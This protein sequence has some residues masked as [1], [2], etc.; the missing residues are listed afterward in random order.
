VSKRLPLVLSALALA[1][2]L[3]GATP[4]GQAA[5]DLVRAAVPLALYAN[6]AG[7]LQGHTASAAPVGGQVPVLDASGGLAA[8]ALRYAPGVVA[9]K[10]VAVNGKPVPLEVGF[11]TTMRAAC[12]AGAVVLGGGYD[13][14]LIAAGNVKITA[15]QADESTQSWTVTVFNIP[16]LDPKTGEIAT[17][18]G[19]GRAIAHCLRT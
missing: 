15:E 3:L 18:T 13:T 9:S 19:R 14:T 7:K 6:N 16:V 17:H 12:P 8:P 10:L 2:S 1:V 4:A 5:A 11:S